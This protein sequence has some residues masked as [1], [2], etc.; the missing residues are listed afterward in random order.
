MSDFRF[1]NPEVFL[2]LVPAV[3]LAALVWR[4]RWSTSSPVLRYSDTNL[5]SAFSAT[6][7]MRLRRL[8]DLMTVA[9]WLLLIVLLARPQVGD[10][11]ISTSG[12]GIDIVLALDIS[13][14]MANDDFAPN[15]LEA[16]KAVITDFVSQRRYDRIGLVVF[17]EQAFYQA[18]PTT[19]YN[20]LLSLVESTPF[21]HELGLGDRTAVGMGIATAANML[22]S[23]NAPS[24]VI[25]LLTDGENNA[26]QID[27]ITAAEAASALGIRIYT[28][29]IG[30]SSSA[31]SDV[32]F[33][34]LQRIANI[35]QGQH[36]VALDRQDLFDIYEEI[37][38][39]EAVDRTNQFRLLWQDV[40]WPLIIAALVLLLI[41]R[42]L[43]NT[44]FQTIP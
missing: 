5:L 23:S 13:D 31:S 2:L 32:D 43:R 21:A 27:P 33:T 18:P 4:N 44:I 19:D 3:L 39:L 42:I 14:S 40:G 34:T 38:G 11:E 1:A 25:I 30:L 36:Y 7:R 16:A 29:G 12:A 20:V 24:R 22:R 28:I 15:R 10:A 6:T 8:P 26:G 17:A 37:S 9:A 35:G 41:E